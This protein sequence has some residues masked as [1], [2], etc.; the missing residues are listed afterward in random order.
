MCSRFR[1]TQL[2]IRLFLLKFCRLRC[3]NNIR[4]RTLGLAIICF[5][6]LIFL[7]SRA[8]AAL[9]VCFGSIKLA[10]HQQQGKL[11]TNLY[12]PTLSEMAA[13]KSLKIP[14]FSLN[15]KNHDGR[16]FICIFQNFK[17]GWGALWTPC[18]L[19]ANLGQTSGTNTPLSASKLRHAVVWAMSHCAH[20]AH[21]STYR[22][23][24]VSKSLLV[25]PTVC[26][27]Y[28]SSETIRL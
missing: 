4:Q 23:T 19:L 1:L 11:K 6:F 20:C 24:R 5:V 16:L 10:I 27:I 2:T 14:F 28:H 22:N 18:I 21:Y 26:L 13:G 9:T 15:R 12:T 25:L 17:G 7:C 3:L 8:Q